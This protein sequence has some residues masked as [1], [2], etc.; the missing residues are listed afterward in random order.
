[1]RC[2]CCWGG[3]A[4]LP[5]LLLPGALRRRPGGQALAP[6]KLISLPLPWL[7]RNGANLP[8]VLLP[9]RAQPRRTRGPRRLHLWLPAR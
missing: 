2:C 4:A 3:R 7:R 9:C 1:M 8:P 5:L 6:R